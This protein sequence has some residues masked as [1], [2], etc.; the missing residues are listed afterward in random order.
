MQRKRV[1]PKND[2]IATMKHAV[3]RQLHTT[4]LTSFYKQS[5]NLDFECQKEAQE[6][7]LIFIRDLHQH[8]K[9]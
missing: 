1:L 7:V 4:L 6:M 9:V 3:A 5:I 8:L 2:R